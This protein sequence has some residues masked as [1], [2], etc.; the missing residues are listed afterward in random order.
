MT[1]Y[2][3]ILPTGLLLP[4]DLRDLALRRVAYAS[5]VLYSVELE[6]HTEV[7]EVWRPLLIALHASI[8]LRWTE[9]AASDTGWFPG[10]ITR[11]QQQA[12]CL[13]AEVISAR[14]EHSCK[15]CS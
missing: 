3:R 9:P 12:E 1:G 11:A 5:A 6:Q 4:R 2:A 13:P 15:N 14:R 8:E 7:S 10:T